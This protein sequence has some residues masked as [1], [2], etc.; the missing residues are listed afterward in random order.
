MCGLMPPAA[1]WAIEPVAT[2]AFSS[3][4]DMS[5]GAGGEALPVRRASW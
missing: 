1:N 4:A 2:L 3:R 5:Y